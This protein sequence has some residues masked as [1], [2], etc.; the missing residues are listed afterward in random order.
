MEEKVARKK[1]T[2]R[3][4]FCSSQFYSDHLQRFEAIH[5][6]I[7]HL[8]VKDQLTIWV[9]ACSCLRRPQNWYAGLNKQLTSQFVE[10]PISISKLFSQIQ[11]DWPRKLDPHISLNQFCQTVRISP[12]PEAAMNALYHFYSGQYPLEILCYE[13]DPLE[14]LQFQIQGKRILTFNPNFR[15]WPTLKYGERDP[16]SFW[17]HDLIHAEHFFSDPQNRQGQVGFYRFIHEILSHKILDAILL[18]D[19]FNKSF[20]YLISDMNSHPIHLIKTLKALLDI[21]AS[22]KVSSAIWDRIGSL[23]SIANHREIQIALG[24]V[25]KELFTTHDAMKLTTFFNQPF[26]LD[27]HHI[28]FS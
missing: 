1:D 7:E 10:T 17:L 9:I 26:D 5:R 12:L 19:E 25:N 14:L 13:P 16:L 2:Y 18:N 3:P 27:H 8:T 11:I 22:S 23:P 4:A 15:E 24:Q 21:H 6:H 20:C 28:L